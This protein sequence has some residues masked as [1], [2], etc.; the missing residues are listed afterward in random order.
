MFWN[1]LTP[2]DADEYRRLGEPIKLWVMWCSLKKSEQAITPRPPCPSDDEFVRHE[3]LAMK[4]WNMGTSAT[5][6]KFSIAYNS[7]EDGCTIVPQALLA[8]AEHEIAI[9]STKV[10]H[11][12]SATLELPAKTPQ[13]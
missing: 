1:N 9:L 12:V 3:L 11:G 8:A 13:K 4:G 10:I 2:T 6:H 7:F 5:L